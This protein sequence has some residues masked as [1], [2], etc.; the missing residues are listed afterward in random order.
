VVLA[1]VESVTGPVV[2]APILESPDTA[3]VSL[4]MLERQR[5]NQD[6]SGEILDPRLLNSIREIAA[7]IP[8]D[9]LR[10]VATLA[11]RATLILAPADEFRTAA[12]GLR[13]RG[14]KVTEHGTDTLQLLRIEPN[15]RPSS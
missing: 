10:E 1:E 15:Q 8:E 5:Q 11:G 3:W 13:E 7:P 9:I 4:Q 14:F 6:R 2:L 12:K